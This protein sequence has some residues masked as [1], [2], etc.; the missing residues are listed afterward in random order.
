MDKT[1][2]IYIVQCSD[3]SLYTGISTDIKRRLREHNTGRGA[4]Y[5]KSRGPVSLLVQF[6]GFNKSEALKNEYKIKQLSRAQKFQIVKLAGDVE[7]LKQ[8]LDHTYQGPYRATRNRR[9]RK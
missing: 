4:K 5:T 9:A 6:T 3:G 1:W 8:F 7:Q 2:S